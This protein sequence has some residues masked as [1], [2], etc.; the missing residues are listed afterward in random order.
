MHYLRLMATNQNLIKIKFPY[1]DV[2]DHQVHAVVRAMRGL[3]VRL[4]EH[5][6]I[7]YPTD[8]DKM[9]KCMQRILMGTVLNKYIQVLAGFKKSDKGL[10]VDQWALGATKDVTMEHFWTWSK[11]ES[12]DGSLDMYLIPDRCRY[13]D[14]YIWF[15]LVKSMWRKYRCT[16]QVH[17]KY[18]HNYSVKAF[19][20]GIFQ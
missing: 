1:I 3:T 15:E 19:K 8:A 11:T 7:T 5:I 12:L 10:S 4:I 9:I 13:F 16:Y 6:E 2:F 20:V 17:I 14:K 18:I